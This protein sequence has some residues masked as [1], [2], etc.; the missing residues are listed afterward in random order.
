[1]HVSLTVP[2][3]ETHP[4]VHAV[5]VALEYIGSELKNLRGTYRSDVTVE[6][7]GPFLSVSLSL[8]LSVSLSLCLSVSLSSVS[9]SRVSVLGL[10]AFF[11]SRVL[12]S[13]TL[14]R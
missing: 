12:R 1:M 4:D 2:L 9:L 6:G 8:C 3:P 5:A 13:L 11:L 10:S 7:M 14:A